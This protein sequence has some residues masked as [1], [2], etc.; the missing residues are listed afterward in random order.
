MMQEIK[1]IFG[2][3]DVAKEA[4]SAAL[5]IS[6]VCGANVVLDRRYNLGTTSRMKYSRSANSA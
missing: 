6:F 3:Q 2:Q 4:N 1:L 5:N